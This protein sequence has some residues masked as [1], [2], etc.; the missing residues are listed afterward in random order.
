RRTGKP[1]RRS[2]GQKPPAVQEI[3]PWRDIGPFQIG[4]EA[5]GHRTLP[6][7]AGGAYRDGVLPQ[8]NAD[9]IVRGRIVTNGRRRHR[10]GA[11]SRRGRQLPPPIL[12]CNGAPSGRGR[13]EATTLSPRT[14]PSDPASTDTVSP[15]RTSPA[16]IISAR[17]SCRSRWITRFSGR[18]P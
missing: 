14:S 12:Q 7:F 15:S 1:E 2:A 9:S 4:H 16:R 11:G 8:N 6:A 10:S 13:L 3:R 17:G 5:A 18:A